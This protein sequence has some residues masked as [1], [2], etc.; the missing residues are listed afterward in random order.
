MDNLDRSDV[1]PETRALLARWQREAEEFRAA[2]KA[3]PDDFLDR[4]LPGAAPFFDA[5]WNG[6]GLAP[7]KRIEMRYCMTHWSNVDRLSA[8]IKAEARARVAAGYHPYPL[9]NLRPAVTGS[10]I[11]LPH[12]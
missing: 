4:W 1:R 11:N 10:R 7:S 12:D 9:S 3:Q 2:P 5:G 6:D 8:W